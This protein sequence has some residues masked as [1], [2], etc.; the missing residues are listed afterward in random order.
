MIELYA[1]N[2]YYF[3]R[4][5]WIRSLKNFVYGVGP[6]ESKAGMY[7]FLPKYNAFASVVVEAP[8]NI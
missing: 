4:K 8:C 6:S 1:G 7:V 5:G 3:R 2:R